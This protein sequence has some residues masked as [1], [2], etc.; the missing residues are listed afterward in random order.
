VYNCNVEQHSRRTRRAPPPLRTS[1]AA[2]IIGLMPS[3]SEHFAA[4][5]LLAVV[6]SPGYREQ[7]YPFLAELRRAAPVA[8][9]RSGVWLVSRYDDV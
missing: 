7:P 4:D 5:R 2:L 3:R 1:P 6:S 9:A 8:R